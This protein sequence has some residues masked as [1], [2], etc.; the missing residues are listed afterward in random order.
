MRLL[1]F[2]ERAEAA[3]IL[4]KTLANEPDPRKAAAHLAGQLTEARAE[5]NAMIERESARLQ[6]QHAEDERSRS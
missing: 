2:A 3:A 5:R 1:T 6:R 4:E